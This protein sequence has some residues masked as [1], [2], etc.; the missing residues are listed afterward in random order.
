MGTYCYKELNAQLSDIDSQMQALAAKKEELTKAI[1]AHKEKLMERFHK[2]QLQLIDC[3]RELQEM[4]LDITDISAQ[5]DNSTI[6]EEACMEN[7]KDVISDKVSDSEAATMVEGNV[8]S[9]F[10]STDTEGYYAKLRTPFFYLF[11]LRNGDYKK[12]CSSP[13]WKHNVPRLLKP[14]QVLTDGP[15]NIVM[16]I[17]NTAYRESYP[18]PDEGCIYSANGIAPTLTATHSD[19]IINIGADPRAKERTAEAV[20]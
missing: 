16:N 12:N 7:Y 19:L 14:L 4:G 1:E 6:S 15:V 18:T 2:L 13:R 9:S 11:G 17:G 5:E 10:D 8:D 20:A 3:A